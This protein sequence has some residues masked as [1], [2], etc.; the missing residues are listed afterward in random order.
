LADYQSREDVLSTVRRVLAADCACDEAAFDLDQHSFLPAA[1]RVGRRRFKQTADPLIVTMGRGVVVSASDE[2]LPWLRER[3]SGLDRDEM[4]FA[5][6]LA[7]LQQRALTTA[8]SVYGPELKYL[9]ALD[10]LN[11]VQYHEH[12]ITLLEGDAVL[13]LYTHRG[14]NNALQYDPEHPQPDVLATVVYQDGSPAG[15]AGASADSDDLWQIGID[16]LPTARGS[17]IGSALV[18]RLTEAIFEHGKVPYYSTSPSNIASQRIAASV[19][20]RPAW[21]ELRSLTP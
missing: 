20:F 13:D 12:V 2:Q 16:V 5:P 1:E 15:I 7:L 3:M 14:F 6:M 11:Q 21:T 9:C 19:G 8:R 18:S 17:G 4:F 10:D